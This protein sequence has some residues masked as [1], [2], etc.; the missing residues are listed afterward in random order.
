[1]RQS[2][3]AHVRSGRL[4]I[5]DGA[6]G[7][8]LIDRGLPPGQPPE[9]WTLERPDLLTEIAREYVDAGAAILTTNT[10][11][12]SPLRLH[13]YGL[14]EQ[15]EDINTTGVELVRRAAGDR[16]WVA[17][18]IGPT[19]MLLRPAGDLTPDAAER[20]FERQI[21]AL[22]SA[23]VDILCIETMTDL[24][25]AA[26]AIA[27]AR[28][29]TRDLPVIATMTFDVAA[30]GAAPF[31]LSVVSV[32]R[33]AVA[34]VEAGADVVGANCG[35]GLEEM[36]AVARA[37]S[38]C[39]PVPIAIRP[40][41][42]LPTRQDGLMVYSQTP[43]DFGAAAHDLLQPGVGFLGGCCGTTPAHIRALAQV[44]QRV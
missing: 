40:N 34:L 33:D 30:R 27:A 20:S 35:R 44:P 6:W 16:A 11:G 1:M 12:A 14:A 32:E 3:L 18:S 36:I 17:A 39:S 23:G 28:K 9:R 15:T 29:V 42:G 2:F 22:V 13:R 7:S 8:L 10:F 5:A 26:L 4:T 25:E 31:T 43:E 24:T 41:A 37:F 21:R 38:A 19:G